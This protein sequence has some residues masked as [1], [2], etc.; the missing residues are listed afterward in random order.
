MKYR[1]NTKTIDEAS[2]NLKD[3]VVNTPLQLSSRLS[4][5]YNANIYI[6]RED[7]QVV[8]SYKIRGAYNLISAI[9]KDNKNVKITCASAG[10]HAQGVAFA[11]SLL[12]IK[13]IIFMPVTTPLQK[14]DRVKYFGGDFVS[15]KLVGSNFDEC[16]KEAKIFT[17]ENGYHF[18]HPFD[19]EKVI[20]GQA[21]V[22]KEIFDKLKNIDYIVCPIGGGGLI[23]GISLYL[24]E[25]NKNI[26]II[27]VEPSGA[28]SMAESIKANKIIKL[29]TV[30]TFVDGVATSRVGENTFNIVKNNVEKI[31]VIEEGQV[32]TT[33]IE[34]YQNDGIITEPAGALAISALENMKTEIKG[35]NVVCILSGGNNDVLRYPEIMERS[36]VFKGLKHYFLI[37]FYQKPGEL[38]KFV[39]KA[40][41]VND[42]IVRFEYIKKTSNERGV[43]LVGIELKNKKDIDGLIY[44]MDEHGITYK[45]ITK[46]DLLYNY[47]I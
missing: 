13:S 4:S 37:E 47:I 15:I 26:K 40:L 32:A 12:K 27:G 18:I 9:H 21:T 41:G 1:V 38:K 2:S 8:R 36:L 29:K 22:G 25:K 23:S 10:N 30:D 11:A 28:A 5:K 20:E 39:N 17:K 7:L 42:D 35:K 44:R 6:K 19:D 43:A 31:K 45:K 34:L 16:Y 24:K 14:I 46:S 3:I 33:M